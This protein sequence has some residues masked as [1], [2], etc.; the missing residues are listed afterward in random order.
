MTR[1][2]T[3]RKLAWSGTREVNERGKR[4]EKTDVEERKTE[5]ES[6]REREREKQRRSR[7]HGQKGLCGSRRS[8]R[9]QRKLR[10]PCLH[11]TNAAEE[12]RC[13]RKIT[14]QLVR[15][16]Q[17][18]AGHSTTVPFGRRREGRTWLQ[19]RIRGKIE[20]GGEN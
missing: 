6:E 19:D 5:R 16:W 9:A 4:R 14:E 3:N 8:F 1:T 7:V 13:S 20:H 2:V 18:V 12:A 11:S 10:T 15:T 17:R